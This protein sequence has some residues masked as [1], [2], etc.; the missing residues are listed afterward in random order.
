L[1]AT[2][3][4]GSSRDIVDISGDGTNNSGP[5]LTPVRDRLIAEGI[6][7]N[8][9]PIAL[10]A[11]AGPDASTAS[12]RQFLERYYQDCV[13]GGP[14]AFAITVGDACRLESA[15]RRKLVMEIAG[16]L[17]EL[18]HASYTTAKHS[19]IDCAGPGERPGR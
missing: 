13:I 3:N 17:P 2:A 18:L 11:N 10:G 16:R 7:I 1:F 14:G 9:L 8:G 19:S 5:P 6:I 4:L 15:I 12:N